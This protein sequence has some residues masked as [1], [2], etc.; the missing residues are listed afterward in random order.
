M[1]VARLFVF[2]LAF[3]LPQ[4]LQAQDPA[5]VAPEQFKVILENDEIRVLEFTGK[6]GSDTPVH[7][8]PR[9]LIYPLADGK[10]IFTLADGTKRTL[11]IK[12]GGA[13]WAQPVTHSHHAVNDNHVLVVEMKTPAPAPKK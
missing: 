4:M 13:I 10:T 5:K 9:H 7:S 2:V 3:A 6:A 1:K 11:E 8:H 12:K